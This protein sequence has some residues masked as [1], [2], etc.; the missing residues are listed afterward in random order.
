[1]LE[2]ESVML[3]RYGVGRATMREALRILEDHGLIILQQGHGGPMVSSLGSRELGRVISLFGQ[4]NGATYRELGEMMLVMEP[5][6]AAQAAERIDDD[7]IKTLRAMIQHERDVE[8]NFDAAVAAA[9]EF[10]NVVAGLS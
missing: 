5:M 8:D 6:I 2:P 4:V 7:G 10:H 1:R 3:T 9:H